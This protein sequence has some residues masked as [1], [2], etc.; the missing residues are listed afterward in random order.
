MK[1]ILE[2][3]AYSRLAQSLRDCCCSI[4]C[5]IQPGVPDSMNAEH[6]INIL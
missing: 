3:S 6:K 5:G 1:N 4:N 2:T